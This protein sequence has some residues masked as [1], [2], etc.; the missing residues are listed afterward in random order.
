M[1][2]PGSQFPPPDPATDSI[3]AQLGMTAFEKEMQQRSKEVQSNV[4]GRGF[5]PQKGTHGTTFVP[6]MTSVDPSNKAEDAKPVHHGLS[7]PDR[8]YYTADQVNVVE[9]ENGWTPRDMSNGG[10][11][12][13]NM[14]AGSRRDT[15]TNPNGTPGS[16]PG[17]PVVH[18]V[19][20]EGT[21]D[22]D[23]NLNPMGKVAGE[24]TA[25]RL[26][27][28]DTEWIIPPS[29]ENRRSPGVQGTLP[30]EN[31]NKYGDSRMGDLNNK[32][33]GGHMTGWTD[34]EDPPSHPR[35]QMQGQRQFGF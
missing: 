6:G 14:A 26:K 19:E 3:M 4:R 23:R 27:I 33:L 20:P 32:V 12:W 30:N 17:R 21:I 15:V 8:A 25:D 9:D 28:T 29:E 11:S 7:D 22:A 13:A 10:W 24:L 35:M 5:D 34:Y 2:P 31:W 1:R 16:V 18:R